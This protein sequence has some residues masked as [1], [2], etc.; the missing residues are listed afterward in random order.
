MGCGVFSVTVSHTTHCKSEPAFSHGEKKK[1][2]RKMLFNKLSLPPFMSPFRV[3]FKLFEA[4]S[5]LKWSWQGA[6]LPNSASLLPLP[7]S[8]CP[9]TPLRSPGWR[10]SLPALWLEIR[11]IVRNHKLNTAAYAEDRTNHS[12]QGGQSC[13]AP[14]TERTSHCGATGVQRDTP[15]PHQLN[16][17]RGLTQFKGPSVGPC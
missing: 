16:Q 1:K 3:I 17:L 12:C 14:S 5:K 6:G 2:R 8:S 4:S 11:A 10:G 15:H 13:P 7:S 9:A